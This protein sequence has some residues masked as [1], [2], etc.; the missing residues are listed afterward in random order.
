MKNHWSVI[1]AALLLPMLFA[2]CGS[3]SKGAATYPLGTFRVLV[4]GTSLSVVDRYNRTIL[5]GSADTFVF[6]SGTPS[7]TDTFGSFAI[8]ETAVWFRPSSFN[9]V[10]SDKSRL[11]IAA[12]TPLGNTSVPAFIII[13]P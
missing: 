5:P 10:S 9:V 1:L 4:S 8:T 12:S 6:G 3:S 2:G 11:V 7:V 13:T